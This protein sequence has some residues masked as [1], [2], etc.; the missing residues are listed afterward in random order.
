MRLIT[1][2]QPAPGQEQAPP[3]RTSDLKTPD[4]AVLKPYIFTTQQANPSG[5]TTKLTIPDPPS[6][7]WNYGIVLAA[8]FNPGNN[9][10]EPFDAPITDNLNNYLGT[11]NASPAYRIWQ[12]SGQK[13]FIIV[14]NALL[15][16]GSNLLIASLQGVQTTDPKVVIP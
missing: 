12:Q 11:T 7:R 6:G 16:I 5:T 15:P 8:A 9:Q 10:F 1:P 13:I 14:Q 3:L 2:Q 4:N